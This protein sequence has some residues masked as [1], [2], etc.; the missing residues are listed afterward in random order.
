MRSC[1]LTCTL[2]NPPHPNRIPSK[3]A[4][5]R[6]YAIDMANVIPSGTDETMKNFKQRIYGVLLSMAN[7]GNRT[8]G[9]QIVR[10]YP[11]IRWER[12]WKNLHAARVSDT[13]KSTWYAAINGIIPTN[14]RL[15]AIRL[16]DTSS[17]SQCGQIDSLQHRM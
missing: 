8:T 7:T 13:V 15:A 9:L 1:E 10:K 17:C 16:I 3:L 5:L 2:A 4:Y 6:Q 12:V 14:D 11:G